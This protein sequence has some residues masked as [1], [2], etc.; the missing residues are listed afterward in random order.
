MAT[1]HDGHRHRLKQ[2]FQKE[3]LDNF[4]DINVLELLLF[5]TISRK[6][7]NPIAHALLDRFGSLAGVL[8]ARP[9]DL[10]TVDGMGESS[11]A[12]LSLIP[13]LLRRYLKDSRKT[14]QILSTTALCGEYLT[15]YFFLARE[16]MVYL[17]CLDAKCMVLDCRLVQTGSVN[18]AGVSI[19]K[20]VETAL[21]SNATS[22]VLAHNHTSGIALASDADRATTR[23]LWKALDAVGIL[24]ADHI[25]VTGDD[26]ISM[27]DDGFFDGMA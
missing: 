27:A 15:P 8:E 5:Y 23:Q 14:G 3:G 12:F 25:I 16:E 18:T 1:I 22:V 19:R 4:N 2:R 13:Q 17:L 7:T 6:D 26:F 10:A 21:S 24:L 9:E 20:I 11:A